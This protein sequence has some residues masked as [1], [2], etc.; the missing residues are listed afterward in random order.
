MPLTEE[1]DNGNEKLP[2]ETERDMFFAM[3]EGRTCEDFIETSRGK[4]KAKYPKQKDLITI[5]RIAAFMRGGI[6]A[7][8]F[9]ESTEYEIQKCAALDVIISGGPAWYERAKKKDKNFSWRNV[10]DAH[11]VDEVYA[12]A[13]QFRQ[14]VQEQLAGHKKPA[15]K[16]A[17][18]ENAGGVPADVGDGLF[19]G[20]S[21]S[22]Q[23]DES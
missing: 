7:S 3:L 18:R 2:E 12:K 5:G 1:I 22:S 17:D 20:V 21:S 13:Q 19:E 6:P 8:Q 9:D 14:K 15:A 23:G 16:E 10:P 4:F 11:F